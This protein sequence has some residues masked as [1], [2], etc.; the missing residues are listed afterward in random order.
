MD[1]PT[2]HCPYTPNNSQGGLIGAVVNAA[3][4][5][6]APNYMPLTRQA[7]GQA[8]YGRSAIPDGPYK[9]QAKK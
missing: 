4:A 2:T 6:A 5:R 8:F 3:I 1:G 9:V 7:N